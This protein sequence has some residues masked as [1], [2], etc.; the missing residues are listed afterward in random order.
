MS[1]A[2]TRPTSPTTRGHGHRLAAR[3]RADVGDAV[4]RCGI[5]RADHERARLVLHRERTLG[6]PGERRRVPAGDEQTRGVDPAPRDLAARGREVTCQPR[7]TSP[8]RPEAERRRGREA[9]RCRF[10]LVAQERPELADRPGDE[11]GARGDVPVGVP[12]RRGR[13]I[14]ARASGARRSRSPARVPRRARRSRRPPR[15][16]ARP[17]RATGTRPD[18]GRARRRGSSSRSAGTRERRS[19]ASSTRR[20]RSVP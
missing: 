13:R 8:V 5:E 15:A 14:V 20:R 10:R 16:R 6:E 3:S 17:P 4:A 9:T 18:A 2:T 1:A 7:S 12:R 19:R 11:P